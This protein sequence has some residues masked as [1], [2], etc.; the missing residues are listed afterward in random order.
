MT[1][2][3]EF[4]RIQSGNAA[5]RP[6][7]RIGIRETHRHRD[8]K[9]GSPR[10]RQLESCIRDAPGQD[11]LADRLTYILPENIP[12]VRVRDSHVPLQVRRTN[13]LVQVRLDIR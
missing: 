11:I 12:K 5:E 2:L 7:K 10:M 3:S 8:I 9:G 4:R 6:R 13:I 1:H